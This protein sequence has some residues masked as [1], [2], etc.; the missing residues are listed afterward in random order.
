MKI[1][2]VRSGGAALS[3]GPE[4]RKLARKQTALPATLS[5]E[6][7]TTP[8]KC[9]VTDL[10]LAGAK[11]DLS[12]TTGAIPYDLAGLPRRV[13]L[14]ITA[15]RMRYQCEVIWRLSNRLGVRF[16]KA[17]VLER[18]PSKPAQAPRVIGRPR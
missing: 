7:L 1:G 8:L 12:R 9:F 5:F 14:M 6:G 15:D 2:A 16:L 17:G 11:I 3:Q 18:Q 13:V 10:S 4:K